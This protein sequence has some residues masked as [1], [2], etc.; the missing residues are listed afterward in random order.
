[1][2]IIMIF[3][4]I[5]RNLFNSALSTAAAIS[6]LPTSRSIDVILP[7]TSAQDIPS[8][9]IIYRKLFNSTLSTTTAISDFQTRRSIEVILHI[10][11]TSVPD[12]HP[13]SRAVSN[14]ILIIGTITGAIML[15]I[16]S[17]LVND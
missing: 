2:I 8:S 1:M 12:D 4:V 5:C 10:G 14:Y 17:T 16:V 3:I 15:L 11:L 13:N 6:D 7:V 9:S